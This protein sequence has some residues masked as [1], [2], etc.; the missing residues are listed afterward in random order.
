MI[1]RYTGHG[2]ARHA[3]P[4]WD[5]GPTQHGK[6]TFVPCLGRYLSPWYSTAQHEIVVGLS[7]AGPN[8][9]GP[10]RAHAGRAGLGPLDIYGNNWIECGDG[11]WVVGR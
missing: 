2:L 5:I 10:D 6:Q 3:G 4:G 7:R 1:N 8:R 9:V 11:E